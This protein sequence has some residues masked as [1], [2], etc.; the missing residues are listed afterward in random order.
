MISVDILLRKIRFFIKDLFPAS[1]WLGHGHTEAGYCFS[2]HLSQPRGWH[3]LTVK[4][5]GD[6]VRI[7]VRFYSYQGAFTQGIIV[8]QNTRRIRVVHLSGT[9]NPLLSLESTDPS[10]RVTLL[11]LRRISSFQAWH[12]ISKKLLRRHPKYK[13][14]K[15]VAKRATTWRDYNQ[16]Q[17]GHYGRSSLSDYRDWL[18]LVEPRL[19]SSWSACREYIG[20]IPF[21]SPIFLVSEDGNPF[22]AVPQGSWVIATVPNQ[23]ISTRAELVLTSVIERNKNCGL[24]YADYDRINVAGARYAPNFKPALNIDLAFSDPMYAVGSVFSA[25]VWNQALLN[26]SGYSTSLSVYGIFLEALRIVSPKNIIHVPQVLFHLIDPLSPSDSDAAHRR[27]SW[28]TVRTV[29][30]YFK[31]HQPSIK[32]DITLLNAGS[33][34]QQVNWHLPSRPPLVSIL[35]PTRDAYP[36]LSAC[37]ASIFSV[38]AGIDFELIIIDNGTVDCDALALLDELQARHNVVVIRDY[39]LFNYSALINKGALS[40]NGELICLLNN[41]TKVITDNWLATLSAHAMREDIGCV[42]PML[43]FADNTVQHG[44]VVLGIGGIAG[45][46]HKYFSS[47]APGYQL[48]LQLCHN[49]TALTG[50]CLVVRSSLW[51]LL[52]GLDE[53][54]LPVN[55]NDVDLCLKACTAGYRNLYVPHVKLYHYE[56]KSRGAPAGL[57]FRQWQKERNIMLDRWRDFLKNDP[58][59]SPHL[60]LA[61]ED[62]S[63]SLRNEGVWERSGAAHCEFK[64]INDEA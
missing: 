44:G 47:E 5:Y 58:A 3:L 56:S 19:L 49:F 25:E 20:N 24:I 34:G 7:F 35:L 4:Y 31:V 59:Y 48:R 60:S 23:I 26:L 64:L 51:R 8:R 15:R 37:V 18:K 36:L 17:C 14:V 10:L 39:G 13:S 54:D 62:F 2:T 38:P 30:E 46:A 1:I 50:A 57:A 6:E 12:L 33:W 42:G 61:H 52:G 21:K 63:Y 45:H 27:A 43:L 28:K 9:C 32:L 40:V 41:D 53:S 29:K 55:Y 22:S 11:K 16:L